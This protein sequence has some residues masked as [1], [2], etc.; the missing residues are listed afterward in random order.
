LGHVVG[1]KVLKE[2]ASVLNETITEPHT[3]SRWGGDEFAMIYKGKKE[4]LEN[5]IF[6]LRHS[7]HQIVKKLRVDSSISFGYLQW[8]SGNNGIEVI[9]QADKAL[10]TS[11]NKKK[12]AV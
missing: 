12:K 1:D 7:Y 3:I 10:Y 5:L 4:H 11:K 8:V 6:E 9:R 2:F